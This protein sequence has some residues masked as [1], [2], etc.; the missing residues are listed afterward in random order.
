MSEPMSQRRRGCLFY[1]CITGLVCLVAIVAA[2]LL[3]LHQLKKM[4]T[5]FTDSSPMTLPTTRLSQAEIGQAQDRVNNFRDAV[6]A[7]R[8]AEPLALTG[9]EL[10]ALIA[11]NPDLRPLKGKVYL[12]IENGVVKGQVSLPLDQL[13]LRV[14]RGRYLNGT[15]KFMILLQN[16]VLEVTPESIVVKGK[17]LPAVYMDKIRTVNLAAGFNT[18]RRAA[19]A[20]GHLQAIQVQDGRLI[21]VPKP[22]GQ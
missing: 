21:L 15:G 4:L 13:G 7:G 6:R 12:T 8:P 16:G 18:D 5:Q 20:L 17:P 14:F 3:G 1:G 11:T 2:F 10:N 19:T 9:D 22:S